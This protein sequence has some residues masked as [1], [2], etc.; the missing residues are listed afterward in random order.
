MMK[1]QS[2]GG[3]EIAAVAGPEIA[4]LCV[5]LSE[6]SRAYVTRLARA[7]LDEELEAGR[8]LFRPVGLRLV[9]GSAAP[10]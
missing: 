2:V 1:Q 10:A 4:D 3:R 8:T 6:K 7:L 9:V 5:Q